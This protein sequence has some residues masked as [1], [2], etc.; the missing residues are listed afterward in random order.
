M[1][2]ANGFVIS[3]VNFKDATD[4]MGWYLNKCTTNASI[5][6][7]DAANLYLCYHEG[8]GGFKKGTYKKKKWLIET[9]QKVASSARNAYHNLSKCDS[10]L[11]ASYL[12]YL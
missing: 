3:R 9:S 1:K 4:F 6:S 11:R 8:I 12:Y 5:P 10:S 7:S 2:Q